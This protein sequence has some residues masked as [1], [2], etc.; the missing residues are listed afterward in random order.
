MSLVARKIGRIRSVRMNGS[1]RGAGGEAETAIA[2][3]SGKAEPGVAVIDGDCIV[4]SPGCAGQ[5]H[6]SVDNRGTREVRYRGCIVWQGGIGVR[7]SAGAR[8]GAGVVA[9]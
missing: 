8:V 2:A 6:S 4:G 5:S 3:R 7:S 1:R 9:R